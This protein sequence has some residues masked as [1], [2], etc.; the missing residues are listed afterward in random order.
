MKPYLTTY[1]NTIGKLIFAFLVVCL[2]TNQTTQ[3]Q[4]LKLKVRKANALGGHAFANSIA[5]STLSLVDREEKIYQEIKNGNVPAFLRRLTKLN[6]TLTVDGKTHVIGFYVLP[7]YLAIGSNDDFVYMPM[8]PILA[9]RVANLLKCALPTRKMVDLIYQNA[10]IKLAPQPIPPTKAMTT[11]PIFIAHNDLVNSSLFPFLADHT[12]SA[13]TAGNKKDIVISNKIY[14][15]PTPRVVIYG[16]HKLDGKAIQP[17]YNKHVNTWA[18][19]SHGVR[20]IQRKIWLDN[21]KTT[22]QKVLAD[23]KYSVLL[24]DE[25]PILT[26]AYPIVKT[27]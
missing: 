19:Y 25:G 4:E 21:R 1:A 3:A 20:L 11:V 16:W 23:P 26:N 15:E 12:K 18:D 13:L 27:Y 10:S 5:D 9:Q 22:L 6:H 24:S 8:T 2:L 7:D 17:L 14:G